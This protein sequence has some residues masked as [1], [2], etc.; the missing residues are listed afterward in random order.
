[1]DDDDDDDNLRYV[2]VSMNETK[3]PQCFWN[4]ALDI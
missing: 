1:M 3:N 2:D 4:W